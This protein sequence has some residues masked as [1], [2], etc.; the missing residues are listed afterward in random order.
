MEME[1]DGICASFS[2]STLRPQVLTPINLLSYIFLR[3]NVLTMKYRVRLSIG[4]KYKT[5]PH[6]GCPLTPLM[7][8]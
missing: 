4:D 6:R 8:G 3:V 1:V 5:I 2:F 7:D